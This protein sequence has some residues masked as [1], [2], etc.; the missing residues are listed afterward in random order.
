MTTYDVVWPRSAKSVDVR[1]LAPRLEKMDGAKVAFLWDYLFR[2]DE[3]W[4]VCT[5]ELG[6]RFPGMEFVGYEEFGSTHGDEEHEVLAALP[7]KLK[8]LKI[9][10]VVSGMG[11]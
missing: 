7:E 11:C 10:A 9:D 4:D 2:G 6:K 8:S 3:I 5:E 1:P